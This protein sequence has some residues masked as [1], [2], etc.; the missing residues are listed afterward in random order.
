MLDRLMG[1]P[2]NLV[3]G[4]ITT[5]PPKCPFASRP[6]LLARDKSSS[7][8]NI[9]NLA[10]NLS[11]DR[12]K[13]GPLKCISSLSFRC[14]LHG[15]NERLFDVSLEGDVCVLSLKETLEEGLYHFRLVAGRRMLAAVAL[16]AK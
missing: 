15:R 6:H 11:E 7:S 5:S 3:A 2:A 12:H 10:K 14:S 13:S 9:S 4:P 16:K 1:M 8:F